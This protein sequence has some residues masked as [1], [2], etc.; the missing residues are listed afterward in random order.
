MKKNIFIL[1]IIFTIIVST[2]TQA[3]SIKNEAVQISAGR[4]HSMAIKDDGSVWAWGYNKYGQL[5]DGSTTDKS[6][7]IQV[8]GLTHISMI[9][10][11][12]SHSLAMKDDGSVWAWGR[13]GSGQLG[14]GSI[15]NRSCPVRVPG[16]SH[17]SM[18]AAGFFHS[19]AI[20]DDGSV[21]AW[22]DNYYGQLGDGSITDKNS[23]VKVNGLS[24][25]TMIAA[26]YFHSL[27]IKDDGSVWA[28]G[29][30]DNGQLGD[31]STTNRNSPVQVLGLSHI[32]KIAAGSYH[33]LAIQ[34][35]CSV[36][37]W[38]RNTSGQLGDGSTT[39]K[40]SPMQV[41]GLSNFSMI[42]A[43]DYYSLA[44]KDDGSVW[45]W[46]YNY[47][48]QLGD[49][50]TTN[51]RSPMQVP[52]LSNVSMIAA[53]TYHSLALKDDGSV[54]TWG[55]NYYGQLGDGNN[56]IKSSPLQVP[57]LS[58]VSMIAVGE[59]HSLA[60]K[61][62]GSVW[63]WGANYYGQ[64]GD[65]N[66]SNKSSPVQ[67]TGLSNVFMITTGSSHSLA[68]KNDGSIWAWG[69]NYYGQLG[70][71]STA[72][73]N[74]PL[75]VAG[76]SNVS[77]IAT[78]S[79]H[80][81]AIRDDG[82]IWAWGHNANGQLGDGSTFHKT[83]PVQVPE[84]SQVAMIAAGFYFSL[85]IK[86]DGSVWAWGYNRYNQLGDGSTTNKSSPIQ[87]PGLSNSSMIAAGNEHSLAIK[88]D[89][90]VWAW[91]NNDS[92]QLGDGSTT[93][94]SSPIQVPGL[95][96]VSMI[97]AGKEH[98]LAIKDDGSVWA[99]GN[100]DSGQL[101]DGSTTNKSSP[102]Q[103]PGLSYVS[104]IAAGDDHSLAIKKDG[105]V[106]AW[107][108]NLY[109]KLGY[110]YPTYLPEPVYSTIQFISKTLT[111]P[112]NNTIS[113]PVINTAHKKITISYNT[114]DETAIAGIDYLSKSASLTF[115]ADE[116]QKD[117]HITILNNPACLHDKTFV[118]NLDAPD[119]IFLNDGS[120]T[121]ITISS[122][123]TVNSPYKNTFTQNMP[124]SGWTYYSSTPNGRIQ[125]IA[126][127]LRM[128]T[129]TDQVINLNEAILNIDL[130]FTT[131]IHLNF[132]QKSIASD[133]C[134][135]LPATYTDLFNGD[136]V[137]IS[138]DGH[139][140]YRIIKSDEL[141]TDNL[142]KNYE[143]DL[144][145]VETEIQANYNENF[146]LN[147]LVKI[148]FQQYGNRKYPSGGR[149]WDDIAITCTTP[150]IMIANKT[151][152]EDTPVISVP[153]HVTNV[154]SPE[155]QYDLSFSSSHP[156]L[157]APENISYTCLS[158]TFY[159]S[160]APTQ[161]TFGNATISITLNDGP[162]DVASTSFTLTVSPV[163]DPPVIS[164]IEDQTIPESSAF[165][166]IRLEDFVTD[167]DN[168]KS[169]IS[170]TA[171]GQKDLTINI[172]NNIATI[173]QP[174]KNW[175]GIETIIFIAEDPEGLTST[176]AVLFTVIP[177]PRVINLSNDP[178]PTKSK[179]WHWSSNK[180]CTFR[181]EINQN[182]SWLPA[183]DFQTMQT[184]TKSNTDG[185]WYL[186]VQAKDDDG[187]LS[188]VNSV[189]VILDNTKPTITGLQNDSIPTVI[190][191]WHLQANEP[192]TFRFEIDQQ[193]N[194]IA[195]GEFDNYTII[196]KRGTLGTWYL[197]VQA[198]DLAGNLSDTVTV[199]A[200]FKIPE[201]E[202]SEPYS[203]CKEDETSV[204]IKLQ[205]SH[206]IDQ[207]VSV[208]FKQNY[209][210]PLDY[211]FSIFGK[212]YQ[213]PDGYVAI[214][215]A[216]QT[217]GSIS[218]N[219]I[220]DDYDELKE[221]IVLELI[222]TNV[223]FGMND[224]HTI[225]I[226]DNDKRGIS[227]INPYDRPLVIE[228]VA[229]QSLTIVLM[230]KPEYDVS[231]QLTC[232]ASPVIIDPDTLMFS[233][234]HWNVN[235]R[236]DISVQN[237]HI[238]KGNFVHDISLIASSDGQ[239]NGM[240]EIISIEIQDDDPLPEP[241]SIS[242]PESPTNNNQVK[243]C[244]ESGGGTEYFRYSFDVKDLTIDAKETGSFC[245][246]DFYGLPEGLYT[247]YV[248]EFNEYINQ[249][250]DPSTCHIEIDTGLP[251]SIL[252]SPK[253][254]TAQSKHFTIT[255]DAADRYKD[256]SCWIGT[257]GSGLSE[258]QLWVAA[259]E[260]TTFQLYA[261]DQEYSIDGYFEYTATKE[262]SYRFITCAIDKAGNVE[263]QNI[264][265]SDVQWAETIY[266]EKFSG[267]AILVVGSVSGQEGLESHTLTANNIV[268]QLNQRNFWPEHIKYFNPYEE[269][270]AG[271]T[272]FK[273]NGETYL[274]AVENVLTQWAPE[275]IQKFPGPLYIIL[276]DH[277][278]PDIF[279]LTG[280]QSLSA[281][282]LNQYLQFLDNV[283]NKKE[284]VL[285]LGTCFS[286]SF[287][288]E[289]SAKGRIIVTSAAANE[290]SYRGPKINPGG[291]R[292]GGFFISNLFNELSKGNNLMDSFNTAVLRT[293]SFTF[294]YQPH[295]KAPFFDFALQHPLLDDNGTGGSNSL[296]LNGDG[297][298]AQN[299][300][301]GHNENQ[302]VEILQTTIAPQQL[303]ADE[304]T[305]SVAVDVH[306]I[307][308][309]K[310]VWVEIRKPGLNIEDM[311]LKHPYD[312]IGL[313][314]SVEMEELDLEFNPQKDTYTLVSDSFDIPGQY[315]IFFYVKDKEGITSG[316]KERVVYKSKE[317]NDSP[318][319]FFPISPMNNES[320]EFSD[321][322]L[323][324]ESTSDPESDIIS[325]SVILSTNTDTFIK[326]R[327]YETMSFISLPKSWDKKEV[328]WKV[329]A[330]DAYGNIT[331]TPE[332]TFKIDNNQDSWG[333]I[334]YFNVY[335]MDTQMP[336]P[337]AKVN[338]LSNDMNLDLLMNANGLYIKRFDQS[339]VYHVAVSAENYTPVNN[340]SIEIIPG[341]IQSFT[342]NLDF[343]SRLGD[344]NRNGKCDIGD[345][346]QSLQVLSGIDNIS[347]YD[348]FA[349]TGDVI[350]LR[351]AI[352]V[353]QQ[354]SEIEQ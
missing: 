333:S 298:I 302:A 159:I 292:D 52:G 84:I 308:N 351:D 229:P 182:P 173:N 140:W 199:S 137:S 260:E 231:V 19:M 317:N 187:N 294:S 79:Y 242:C 299:I 323:E 349:L 69:A 163:N 271:E 63:A 90:S 190:K 234:D 12:D 306:N 17:I 51:K 67:V 65:G 287:I 259:P 338:V 245:Y 186:H 223:T 201:V 288:D 218:L 226:N 339:G 279:H 145:E 178:N 1:S 183:G 143:V 8:P 25:V 158:N 342:F 118:L 123:K 148:K 171:I 134:T 321:V 353:L 289:I 311:R 151:T 272:D 116:T 335:D 2:R 350:E 189:F 131:N 270:Q 85:A 68:I 176:G 315:I 211:R 232:E 4:N 322:I 276:I 328:L 241:P 300:V 175:S 247:F 11:G 313:Q 57:G 105:S 132:F 7:P 255:Y 316:Y 34:D 304:N 149:E 312:N 152:I 222:E 106:W 28:W 142:G 71:G 216:G 119:D 82:S 220:D 210:Y 227:V 262:G 208:K 293:E 47:Y 341:E 59:C 166:P 277:G 26:G 113:I 275:Q 10:A 239:Y 109:G 33:S 330:I 325:Y 219:V 280:T 184:A 103:V 207:D 147:G 49:G 146:H 273:E 22:G 107:G 35:D 3:I 27:A 209:N 250:S 301:L 290:P 195:S 97:A 46:G 170:W 101:G 252:E 215:K 130:S 125:A 94:K 244:W 31:G 320:S 235:Q 326:E 172:T 346:V 45:T 50:S 296:P 40:S 265:N 233:P 297:Y 191:N 126:G 60:I 156:S 329:Q 76:L 278:S 352:F 29:Y 264:Q 23:P 21:W 303:K 213:L 336:V 327:I 80:G 197:H 324:W 266:T 48:G 95:S 162:A 15:T 41:P 295:I 196:Q 117:I 167:I 18:I 81:I 309:V 154:L 24:H 286:G 319:S 153:L 56:T 254:V 39:N 91:G 281:E 202:F 185:K 58:N 198:K 37:A 237:D 257:S 55:Y 164:D 291:V 72:Y 283:A 66:N 160:L 263:H 144:S 78:G 155:C 251:C 16:L 9:A 141:L 13:N 53:G 310:R 83:S 135:S 256:E 217:E 88:D 121:I 64:L 243:W 110:G 269:K 332:W 99:W 318:L 180:A 224:F 77:K 104:M 206:A 108:S 337:H 120:Q 345:A 38:G 261:I 139:T 128:D 238:F 150:I 43:G 340:E 225:I 111:T 192:A 174:N 136:G 181:F 267:Y 157:I 61:N 102:I 248:Q 112:P 74:S 228:N 221:G 133:I 87:V 249:W 114:T 122:S 236:V 347:Y 165:T 129:N 214:I 246:Q 86:D 212:D 42:A 115:R 73:K 20:K 240:S 258:I 93:N 177:K 200:E 188:E 334:V 343:I 92:G 268:T 100:N 168:K 179:T 331:E 284:I 70:I 44:I 305:L 282:K 30:N 54:W 344:I 75:Q 62:D 274:Q 6:C 204:K 348:P 124:A 96:Y 203:E 307:D 32:F 5:G 98:S 285:I 127:C 205:L 161:D 89:G 314:Q 138:T 230:S 253:A 194:W 169:D 36:W 354:L 14:D 193:E